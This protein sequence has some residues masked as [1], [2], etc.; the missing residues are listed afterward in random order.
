MMLSNIDPRL[1][2]AWHPV[3][4]VNEVSTDPRRVWLLGDPWVLVQS[5]ADDV[6]RAHRDVCPH[7]RAPL[8][9]GALLEDGTLQCGYHGWRFDACGTCVAIPA[10]GGAA[11]IPSRANLHSAAAVAVVAGMVWIAPEEPLTELPDVSATVVG[12]GERAFLSGHLAPIS[13]PGSAGAMLDNFLDV[14]HFPF[15]H[16]GTFGT[17]ESDKVDEYEVER[18]PTGFRAITEH[19]FANHEDP[20]VASGERPLLQRRRMTYVYTAPFTATLRLDYVDAGGTNLIVFAVQ[21]ERDGH[22]RVYTTIYRNDIAP[23]AMDDAVKFEERVLAE[24]LVIQS[25]MPS[26]L[27]LDLTVE[28]HTKADR[29]TIELRRVLSDFLQRAMPRSQPTPSP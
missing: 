6:P 14:A 2:Q 17:D 23:E 28:V 4:L 27:P 18:T 9:A 29:V 21:P 25:R 22:C 15:V 24:D 20:A 7:R 5:P 16:A 12:G 26:T 13:T 10:L 8:S 11:T 19:T 3:A 1:A